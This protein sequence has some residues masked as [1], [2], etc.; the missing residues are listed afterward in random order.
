MGR[1]FVFSRRPF[2]D[3]A[4][5]RHNWFLLALNLPRMMS[6]RQANVKRKVCGRVCWPAKSSFGIEGHAGKLRQEGGFVANNPKKNLKLRQER[7][8]PLL[9]ELELLSII[10]LRI[11]RA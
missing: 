3:A 5:V 8:I 7:N 11:C 2:T 10:Q 6:N 4:R 9:T 1:I